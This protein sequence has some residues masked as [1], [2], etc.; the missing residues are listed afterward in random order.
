VWPAVVPVDTRFRDASKTGQVPSVFDTKARGVQAYD[1][2]LR[3]LLRPASQA[4]SA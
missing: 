2:L 3:Y 1:A 4:M